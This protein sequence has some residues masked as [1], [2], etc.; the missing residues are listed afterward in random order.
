MRL[1]AL[2]EN[3]ALHE[4]AAVTLVVAVTAICALVLLIV[5]WSRN[6]HLAVPLAR[7]VGIAVALVAAL[8]GVV[9]GAA[10]AG[11]VAWLCVGAAVASVWL[12]SPRRQG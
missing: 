10:G 8:L 3:P 9:A 5:M 4:R 11:L 6:G 2:V 7:A 1:V 12:L